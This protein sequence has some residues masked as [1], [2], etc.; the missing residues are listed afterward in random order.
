MGFDILRCDP[1][2]QVRRVARVHARQRDSYPRRRRKWFWEFDRGVKPSLSGAAVQ[3]PLTRIG[4][5]NEIERFQFGKH[6]WKNQLTT[7]R[8][9]FRRLVMRK[10]RWRG[11]CKEAA[12]ALQAD[13]SSGGNCATDIGHG[14]TLVP[15][16]LLDLF[17]T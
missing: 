8:E 3:T 6:Y 2:P 15:P 14:V 13:E 9:M 17:K 1:D 12:R 16:E 10:P 7:V 4:R 5:L 11:R